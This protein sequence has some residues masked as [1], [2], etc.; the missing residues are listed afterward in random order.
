MLDQSGVLGGAELSLL[1][2]MKHMRANADVLL[3]DDGP[4]RAA[5]EEIGARVDVVE[6]GALAGVRKQG[7]VSLGALAQ[8]WRLVRD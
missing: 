1:E 8:L 3:F 7:G 6:Q 5:L 4:F 2:I